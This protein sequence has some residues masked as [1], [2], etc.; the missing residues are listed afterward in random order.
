MRKVVIDWDIKRA[1][2]IKERK[3]EKERKGKRAK[4]DERGWAFLFLCKGKVR[5]AKVIQ[6]RE[7]SA[8]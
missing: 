8:S 1:V 7:T 6:N 3:R 5:I 4:R 2:A